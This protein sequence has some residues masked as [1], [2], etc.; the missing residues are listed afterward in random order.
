MFKTGQAL[1]LRQRRT[2]CPRTSRGGHAAFPRS[3]SHSWTR[4]RP[5]HELY[6]AGNRTWTRT[7]S[8]RVQ[9]TTAFSPRQ[10]SCPRTIHVRAQATASIVRDR[11]TAADV[12]CPQ[13]VRGRELSTSANWL[14][15]QSVRDRGLAKNYPRRYIAVSILPPIN[16]P[17]HVR[18]IPA[19]VL[20]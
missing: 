8:V 9:S 6:S 4:H 11:A 13:A 12:H 3:I 18:I 1:P 14:R 10:Q 16:F 17:V 19:H 7:F 2:W 15:A 5:V 20:I